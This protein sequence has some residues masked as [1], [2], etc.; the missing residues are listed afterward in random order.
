MKKNK[1]KKPSAG[2][3]SDSVFE[4]DTRPNISTTIGSS[5]CNILFSKRS[6]DTLTVAKRFLVVTDRLKKKKIMSTK[7]PWEKS[8]IN[9]STFMISYKPAASPRDLT[10]HPFCLYHINI[11]IVATFLRHHKPPQSLLSPRRILYFI[12]YYY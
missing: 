10:C 2:L 11:R 3:S 8:N 9:Y 1:I 4:R 5:S 12:L 6:F 7:I